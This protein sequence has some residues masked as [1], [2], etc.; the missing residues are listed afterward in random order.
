MKIVIKNKSTITTD[1]LCVMKNRLE[2][3]ILLEDKGFTTKLDR[4]TKR[5]RC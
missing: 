1:T 2:S 3:V 5:K 4:D